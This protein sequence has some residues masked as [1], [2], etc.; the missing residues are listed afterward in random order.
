VPYPALPASYFCT[1]STVLNTFLCCNK[2]LCNVDPTL[3][4]QGIKY[5]QAFCTNYTSSLPNLNVNV[6]DGGCPP[7][8]EWYV[9]QTDSTTTTAIPATSSAS[10]TTIAA[11]NGG[12]MSAGTVVSIVL[13]ILAATSVICG[14]V[15]F[16]FAVRRRARAE[17]D[18]VSKDLTKDQQAQAILS[19][20][21]RGTGKGREKPQKH[22]IVLDSPE[23]AGGGEVEDVGEQEEG[24]VV[25]EKSG[26]HDEEKLELLNHAG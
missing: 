3:R 4:N 26:G 11:S 17:K 1:N 10:A 6:I 21:L 2:N 14:W 13:P 19:A 12:G 23:Q 24:V 8:P 9:T 22:M 20:T 15:W 25:A 16:F 7:G 18:K 5:L